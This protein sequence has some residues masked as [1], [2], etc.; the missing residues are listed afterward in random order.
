MVGVRK[1]DTEEV[2][3]RAMRTFWRYGFDA[4]SIQDL[5]DATGLGRGSL[6]GAFQDKETLFLA[7]IDRYLRNSRTE[8]AA[9]LSAPDIRDAIHGYLHQLI[10]TLTSESAEAGCFLILASMSS[11]ARSGKVRRR[12]QRAFAEEERALYDRLRSAEQAGDLPEGSDPQTLA[13]FFVAQGRAIG[14]TARSNADPA[15]LHDIA[16]TSLTV[17]GPSKGAH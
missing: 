8:W 2:L 13:R 6:Y 4:T 5:T 3:E 12:L 10:A 17:L 9:T 7:A 14:V 16:A 11:E 1:F 15:L